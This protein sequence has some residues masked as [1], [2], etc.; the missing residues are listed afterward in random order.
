MRLEWDEDKRQANLLKHS[1]DFV[2]AET[3]LEGYTVTM[4]DVRRD[5]HE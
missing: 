4:E 1:L 3:V 2:D 5:Y